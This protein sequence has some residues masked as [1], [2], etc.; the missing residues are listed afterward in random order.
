V[1]LILGGFVMVL[2]VPACVVSSITSLVANQSQS[3]NS[4]Q[5]MDPGGSTSSGSGATLGSAGTPSSTPTASPTTPALAT[6]SS[7]AVSSA[8]PPPP[9]ANDPPPPPPP[10]DE[11]PPPPPPPPPADPC[12]PN[13]EGAC[14]PIAS[15]VDCAGGSGDGPA[16][17]RG[18]VY[19]VGSDIYDLDRDGNGVGC[20]S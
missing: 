3:D 2:C 4:Q 17:V 13:Y 12:D 15:D 1:L 16:Y 7:P 18:P 10:A 9:P 20:E 14:V 6:T 19:V 5:S 11:P 8:P